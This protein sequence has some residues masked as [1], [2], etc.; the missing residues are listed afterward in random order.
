MSEFK[1]SVINIIQQVPFGKV[2]SYGQV[3]VYVGVPRAAR[4]VGWIL[5]QTEGK[6]DLPW[7]RVVNNQGRIS[8]KGTEFN[9]PL[10]MKRMLESENVSVTDDY[11]F[12][13]EKYRFRPSQDQLKYWQL[14]DQYIQTVCTK[15][16]I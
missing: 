4:Q 5:N 9:T 11:T 7:W 15:Y 3:A 2:V 14:D 8:I 12:D 1:D 13:I 10:L 16:G 6:V